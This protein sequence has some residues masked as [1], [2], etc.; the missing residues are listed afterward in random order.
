MKL[1]SFPTDKSPIILLRKD[2]KVKALL[3]SLPFDKHKPKKLFEIQLLQMN[4]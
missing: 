2:N 4:M 3:P 1:P